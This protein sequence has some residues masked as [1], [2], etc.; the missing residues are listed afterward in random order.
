MLPMFK[1][2]ILNLA[3]TREY[4]DGSIRHGY[5][6]VAPLDENGFLDSKLFNGHKD[7]C[8]VRRFWGDEPFRDGRL[9]LRP[10]GAGGATWGIDYDDRTDDDDES[11]YRFGNH[12]FVEGEYLS[13]RDDEGELNTFRVVKVQSA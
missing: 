5:E 9:T 10:G 3:R 12:K 11:G 7:R 6:I 4:P 2:I 1:R 13:I 8:R